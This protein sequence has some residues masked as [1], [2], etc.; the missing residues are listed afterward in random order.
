MRSNVQSCGAPPAKKDDEVEEEDADAQKRGEAR[1]PGSVKCRGCGKDNS[2]GY[3]F[4][5]VA[6]QRPHS[7]THAPPG[8]WKTTQERRRG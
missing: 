4:C 3:R 2:V 6:R 5:K 8:L 1:S 7:F